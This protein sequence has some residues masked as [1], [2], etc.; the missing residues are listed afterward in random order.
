MAS[1]EKSELVE[2]LFQIEAI[3]FGDFILKS[4][5]QSPVYV[6]FRVIVSHPEI[7]RQVSA[8]LWNTASDSKADFSVICGVPYT[9]LPIASCISVTHNIPMVMRR[10]EAK[11]YGT[12]RLIEGVFAAGSKCLVIEDVVTSG[13]SVLE[14]VEALSSADLRVTDAV[15]LLDRFQGGKEML[16]YQGISL[17]SLLTLPEVIEL[18]C[19]KG[20]VDPEMAEKVR[21]FLSA[22]KFQPSSL[23]RKE[24]E[25]P[26]SKLSFEE[27]AIIA[28]HPLTKRLF[29]IISEKK[30]N[31]AVSVDFTTSGEVLSLV[32]KVGPHVCIVKTHVDI[33]EDFTPSFTQSL[34]QLAEKHNFVIFEDRKFADIGNTVKNQFSKGLYHIAD[35]ADLVNAHAIPGDGVVKGLKEMGTPLGR[36]CLLIAEMSSAG[37]LATGEY[38][39]R[40]VEMAKNHKDF[41]VG[42]ISQSC[43]LDDPQFV[44]MTPGVQLRTGGDALGQ[45]YLT[46]TEVIIN[47]GSD[48]VIVGRGIYQAAD[49]LKAAVDFKEAAYNAYMKRTRN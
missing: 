22:N 8:M 23:T 34:Q 31:L 21:K 39:T 3:K 42:F 46:P 6:D 41:V 5:I 36:A 13:S 48:V 25:K 49:P 43:L 38:T 40:V 30:S 27:R 15:V 29:Q 14:T 32:E 28:T 9:A 26:G 18:L 2:K 16:K 37:S 11:A 45:Q 17:H 35:W 44:H 33:L 19:R 1:E 10:K 4:G 24:P 12:K 7:M 20:K 47:K